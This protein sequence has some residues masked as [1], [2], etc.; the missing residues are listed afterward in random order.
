[1]ERS[2]A[3]SEDEEYRLGGAFSNREV[4]KGLR[5]ETVCSI[6]PTHSPMETEKLR[7]QKEFQ[8]G[9]RSISIRNS[10][11]LLKLK[12]KWFK[13]DR[14]FFHL[15]K[16]R[17]GIGSSAIR[18]NPCGHP[19]GTWAPFIFLLHPLEFMASTFKLASDQHRG[20]ISSHHKLCSKQNSPSYRAFS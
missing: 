3:G 17:V 18:A 16:R 10:F 1:M 8:L 11:E 19:S 6:Y 7:I 9:R 15:H 5:E 13:Q 12:S 20:F 14:S 4:Q 2:E